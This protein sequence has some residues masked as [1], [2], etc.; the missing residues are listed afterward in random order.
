MPNGE[1]NIGGY[2]TYSFNDSDGVAI[3]TLLLHK[4]RKIKVHFAEGDKTPN[5]DGW[6]ELCTEGKKSRCQ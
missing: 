6:F 3:L 1:I 5:I 4:D 2:D